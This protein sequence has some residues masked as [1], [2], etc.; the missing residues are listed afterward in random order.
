M[1][2]KAPGKH[3]RK[4][5]SLIEV[6]DAFPDDATA[7]RWFTE[8][9]WPDGPS[10]HYCGSS[11][12]Q[13]GTKHK[14]MPYRCREKECGKR[15]SVRTGTVMHASN[16]PY[17][18][19]AVAIYLLL[20]SLKSVSSMKLHRD[21][22]I[23]QRSAW[24]LA[25]RIRK[26]FEENGGLF[27]GPVEVDESYFG[28]RRANMSK[29]KRKNLS[30]RGTAGKTA[31]VGAKDRAT[32][33]VR[34]AVVS[35]TDTESLQGFV[36]ENAAPGAT[37]YTDEAAAYHGIPFEHEAVKHS[38]GEYVRDMSHVNGVESF[39]SILKR[40]HKGTF[41][42]I[43]P[44]HLDR[45]VQEFAGRHNIRCLDTLDQMAIVARGM[46]GKRLRYWDLV[47]THV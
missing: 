36:V 9:R 32:G 29:A 1:A 2:Q 25:H 24:H 10:C 34:A 40:A 12:V 47:S 20:T 23:T 11:N 6:M 16:L 35:S 18:T 27:A 26:A 3:F 21:L 37:V 28:G 31:V 41:H 33:R 46:D 43:S 22:D 4:G 30:G 17:R 5:M 7:E 39:W 19:W 38:V 14:S 15:F 8:I 44:E 42:Q 45:Y 13:S